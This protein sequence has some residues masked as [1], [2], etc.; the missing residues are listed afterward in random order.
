MV[1]IKLTPV[2]LEEKK[3]RGRR[4]KARG[5]VPKLDP[6]LWAAADKL[7][8]HMDA[9]ECKHVVLG[10]I[11]LKYISETFE[12]YQNKLKED[13]ASIKSK[14]YLEKPDECEAALENRGEY[15]L[16]TTGSRWS[17]FWRSFPI[18][19]YLVA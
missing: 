9:A 19:A 7:R 15:F 18:P 14:L 13:I 1:P 2:K 10:L 8:G 3:K 6:T 12:E 17:R 16:G 4:P 11:F 5:A